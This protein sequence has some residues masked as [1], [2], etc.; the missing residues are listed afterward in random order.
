MTL[1]TRVAKKSNPSNLDYIQ[2]NHTVYM[3]WMQ[4]C[5]LYTKFFQCDAGKHAAKLNASVGCRQIVASIGFISNFCIQ[6]V[7]SS[8]NYHNKAKIMQAYLQPNCL[9]CH[10]SCVSISSSISQYWWSLY[11]LFNFLAWFFCICVVTFS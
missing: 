11:T 10:G 9:N 2:I 3:Y 7:S 5:C 8:C 4:Q 1:D 6:S